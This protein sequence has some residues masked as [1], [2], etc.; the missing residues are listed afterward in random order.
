MMMIYRPR[1]T[2]APH[3]PTPQNHPSPATTSPPAAS[4]PRVTHPRRY[5]S[6][7]RGRRAIALL[8][9]ALISLGVV[10]A[11]ALV[12]AGVATPALA[13]TCAVGNA[14][15][16][17]GISPG[18]VDIWAGIRIPG[19]PGQPG[20]PATPGGYDGPFR[21]GTDPYPVFV[22]D[23]TFAVCVLFV[24]W[25]W[26][27]PRP[28]IPGTP[29]QPA[30]PDLELSDLQ[31]FVPENPTI[32]TQPV[33]WTVAGLPTNFLAGARRHVVSGMVLGWSVEVAFT[34]VRYDWQY[35]DGTVGSTTSAGASWQAL[36]SSEFAR[37]STSHV[38]AMPGTYTATVSA[39]Y[40]VSY[41]FAGDAWNDV[42]GE[43]SAGSGP[44]TLVT[45]R[46]DRALVTST[47]GQ[48]LGFAGCPGGTGR[49]G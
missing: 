17:A 44:V 21:F 24:E 10:G 2:H 26:Y 31:H 43:V 33:G 27:C 11:L 38:F 9:S 15:Q 16:G 7:P 13:A 48:V 3:S 49:L 46:Y 36:G 22:G 5:R 39:V 28:G 6:L 34:P 29:E 8:L 19:Q 40:R 20:T 35:G 12:P 47:C 14:C 45:A 18:G 41:R 32:A 1:Q 42:A 30:V 4:P 25:P 37:T 23:V